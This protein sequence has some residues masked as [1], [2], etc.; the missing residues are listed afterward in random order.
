MLKNKMKKMIIAYLDIL[1]G[2]QYPSTSLTSV[3]VIILP[4]S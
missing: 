1:E 3:T 2:F 4:K